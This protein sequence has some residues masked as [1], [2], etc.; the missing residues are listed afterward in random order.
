MTIPHP[1]HV[2]D[3][4]VR[5]AAARRTTLLLLLEQWGPGYQRVTGNGVRYVAEIA[6]APDE[7]W[8]WLADYC[9]AHPQVWQEKIVLNPEQWHQLRREQGR[10]QHEEATTA[11]HAGDFATAR[12]RLDDA[13]AYGAVLDDEWVRLHH[14]ITRTETACNSAVPMSQPGQGER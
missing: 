3:V 2:D 13:L 8:R 1:V 5:R 4:A 7:E 9:T 11:F 6:Q 10:Q 14:L 12:D